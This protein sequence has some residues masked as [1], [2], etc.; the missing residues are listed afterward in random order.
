MKKKEADRADNDHV[1]L[2]RLLEAYTPL[3]RQKFLNKIDKILCSFLN[4]QEVD[5]PWLNPKTFQKKR[6]KLTR[7]LR[8]I[9][10]RI[11]YEDNEKKGRVIH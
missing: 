8:L 6:L 7:R 5:L 10:A 2:V 3:E 11:E 1:K 4:L 9:V